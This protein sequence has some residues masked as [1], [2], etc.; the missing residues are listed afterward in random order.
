MM[1]DAYNS[2]GWEPFILDSVYKESPLREHNIVPG[3]AIVRF[4]AWLRQA[5]SLF[6]LRE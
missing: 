2:F 3:D 1:T 4:V 5:S 6:D